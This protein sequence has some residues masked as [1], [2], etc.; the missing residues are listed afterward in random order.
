MDTKIQE[1]IAE[2]KK[3][4]GVTCAV[5]DF[6]ILTLG[7]VKS[8]IKVLVQSEEATKNLADFIEQ[9]VKL[10]GIIDGDDEYKF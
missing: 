1:A 3:S 4:M 9:G 10:G 8:N 2:F 5:L 7:L 6:A